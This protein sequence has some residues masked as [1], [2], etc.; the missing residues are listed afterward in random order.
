MAWIGQHRSMRHEET[1]ACPPASHE[2]MQVIES[3]MP[4][5]PFVAAM[6]TVTGV[7]GIFGDAADRSVGSDMHH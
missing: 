7:T 6:T 2:A 3:A 4:P 5:M 1:T